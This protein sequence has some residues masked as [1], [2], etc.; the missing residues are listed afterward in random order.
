MS[1]PVFVS[2]PSIAWNTTK[3]QKWD[4]KVQKYGGGRRKTLSRW[5]YPE[6]EL[7]CEY[8]CLDPSELEYTAGFFASARG[9][10]GAFLWYDLEDHKQT[11]VRIGTGDGATTGFQLVRNLGGLFVEP[12]LDIVSETLMVFIDNIAAE[13]V[14]EENGWVE[15]AAPADGAIVTASFEYYWRVA[16]AD[17]EKTWSN[18]WYNFYNLKSVKLVTVK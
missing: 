5:S 11:K 16:F 13:A 15:T 1:L 17:D 6:W 8:T 12:V 14:L 18:F 7:S 3:T 2:P 10:A 9:R 4:T